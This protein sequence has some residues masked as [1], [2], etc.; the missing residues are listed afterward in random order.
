VTEIGGGLVEVAC[1]QG[2]LCL[3]GFEMKQQAIR[4]SELIR[5]T[6]EGLS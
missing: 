5:T 1:E 6:R 4:P 2:K 3:L